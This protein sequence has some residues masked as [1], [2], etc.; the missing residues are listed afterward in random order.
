[1]SSAQGRCLQIQR[2]PPLLQ[3]PLLTEAHVLP[4]S[5][6]ARA[7]HNDVIDHG[8][9]D[10]IAC[11]LQLPRTRDV[12]RGRSG[13]TAGMIVN[14]DD[15]GT[16]LSDG[17]TKHF[18]SVD[19]TPIH[20]PQGDALIAHQ[21]VFRVEQER[22]KFFLHRPAKV[23]SK[24]PHHISRATH[25]AGFRDALDR[26]SLGQGERR[27]KLNG[28][29]NP[30]TTNRPQFSDR[31]ATQPPK[32]SPESRQYIP[33]EA[34]YRPASNTVPENKSNQLR[35]AQRIRTMSHHALPRTLSLRQL[36]N[37]MDPRVMTSLPI[38]RH[39]ACP[40]ASGGTLDH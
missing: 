39:A 35:I 23:L 2:C 8:D 31:R 4:T 17:C 25:F 37:Q 12:L 3:Q 15:P 10:N 20:Q 40:L 30:N 36:G 24:E 22:V 11:L 19:M 34:K 18:T 28:F 21:T 14:Q 1:M 5:P 33:R 13:I 7:S 38:V 26:E 9:A 32:I 27:P 29:G 6:N 16:S